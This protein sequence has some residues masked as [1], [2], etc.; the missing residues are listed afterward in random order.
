MTI[1][2]KFGCNFVK[3]VTSG[4]GF[5]KGVI[6]PVLGNNDGI[7]IVREKWAGRT[8]DPG[9]DSSDPYIFLACTGGA[10]EG[11]F[12][13]FDDSGKPSFDPWPSDE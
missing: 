13:N 2:L 4:D 12:N 6:Y 11:I 8:N 5:E 3:C 7:N 1:K 10:G 9:G